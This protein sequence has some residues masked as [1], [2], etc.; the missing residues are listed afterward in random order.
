MERLNVLLGYAGAT[1]LGVLLLASGHQ[2]AA[3]M[4]GMYARD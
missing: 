4:L 1:G 3:L 2:L